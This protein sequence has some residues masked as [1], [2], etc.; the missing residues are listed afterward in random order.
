MLLVLVHALLL[1][2]FHLDCVF[3][4]VFCHTITYL[5]VLHLR[6]LSICE[7]VL[8]LLIENTRHLPFLLAARICTLLQQVFGLLILPFLI[9]VA[10]LFY[11]L[12]L[13]SCQCPFLCD[14]VLDLVVACPQFVAC[15]RGSLEKLGN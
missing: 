5:I 9:V 13:W 11:C 14:I 6:N 8:N 1:Y 3:L 15:M 4:N 10:W 12:L 2:S 7:V